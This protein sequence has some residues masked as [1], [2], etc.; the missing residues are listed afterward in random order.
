MADLFD[1]AMTA[2]FVN[3]IRDVTDTFFKYPVTLGDGLEAIELLCSRKSIKNELL[4]QETGESIDQA[5]NLSFN[6][7][8]L[9]E[10]GLIDSDGT[11]LIGYDTPVWMDGQRYMITKLADPT[12][13]RDEKLMVVM[14]VVR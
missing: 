6:R 13:F 5:F 7:K 4:A 14:E 10:K 12:V 9:D 3:A 1:D 11:L 8:Y 2:D